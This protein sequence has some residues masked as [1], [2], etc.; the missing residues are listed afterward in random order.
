MREYK[1]KKGDT[2]LC[3]KDYEMKDGSI[4]YTKD[5]VYESDI[6]GSIT[7]NEYCTFHE[8]EGLENFFEYF[9]PLDNTKLPVGVK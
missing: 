2:F 6:E 8:M 9:K 5:S 7:D 3:L 1:I 4:D